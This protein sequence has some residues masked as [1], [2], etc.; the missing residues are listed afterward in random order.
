MR[1]FSLSPSVAPKVETQ[2]LAWLEATRNKNSPTKVPSTIKW[3]TGGLPRA[4]RHDRLVGNGIYPLH[5][6]HFF[7]ANKSTTSAVV[8]FARC[9]RLYGTIAL[10]SSFGHRSILDSTDGATT[11]NDHLLLKVSPFQFLAIPP[12]RSTAEE[13]DN[14]TQCNTR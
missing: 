12:M 14:T 8:C 6:N 7:R 11:T 2:S 10:A 4:L 9:H 1:W 5:T 13:E 3:I